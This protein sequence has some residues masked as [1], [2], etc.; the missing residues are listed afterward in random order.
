[1][2]R[3]ANSG[4]VC[5]VLHVIEVV[6]GLREIEPSAHWPSHMW[7]MI[8]EH[9]EQAAAQS[10]RLAPRSDPRQI[11]APAIGTLTNMLFLGEYWVL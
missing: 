5:E 7:C 11:W 9:T 10:M 6:V 2:I 8:S 4:Q 3:D 1:M